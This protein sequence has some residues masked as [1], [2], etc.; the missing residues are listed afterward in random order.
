MMGIFV[1]AVDDHFSVYICIFCRR[2]CNNR[3]DDHKQV[4]WGVATAAVG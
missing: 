1:W 2:G 4:C 3:L